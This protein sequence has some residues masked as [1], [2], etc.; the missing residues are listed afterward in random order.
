MYFKNVNALLKFP[1]V[2]SLNLSF[3]YIN[4]LYSQDYII[5]QYLLE[6]R[7]NHNYH[8]F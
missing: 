6:W 4:Q 2:M 7:R 3:K 5:N 1:G 8:N